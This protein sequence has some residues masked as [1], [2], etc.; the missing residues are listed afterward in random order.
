MMELRIESALILS[1]H[2]DDMELGAGA[3]VRKLVEKGV[4]IKSLVLSD[5][6]RSVPDGFSEDSLREEC[7]AAAAHLGIKDLTIL[8]FPV[9]E[10]PKH[11]QDILEEIYSFR[12]QMKPDLVIAPWKEDLHQDHS[13][14]GAEAIRAFMRT[15]S[16]LW[17]YQIPGTCPGFNPD[18]FITLTEE[19]A[20]SKVEMLQ[21]YKTQVGRRDYFEP[22]KI[23]GYLSYFGSFI[24]AT[25]AE[26]FMEIKSTISIL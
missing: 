17:S 19:D 26:G 6:K 14:V 5:C 12:K 21:S 8:E 16:S 7:Q 20:N 13:T 23:R 9:R 2:T 4:H 25:Y 24:G 1:A 18:I 10:F 11:R 3:T 15:D 22:E